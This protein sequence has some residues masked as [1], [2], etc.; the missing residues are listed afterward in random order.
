M[1]KKEKDAKPAGNGYDPE[2]VKQVVKSCEELDAEIATIMS[3]AM[4]ACKDKHSEK[5]DIIDDAKKSYGIP[6]K[7]VRAVL[8]IR[9]LERKAEKTRDDL[10]A[11]SQDRVDMI[12]H[13]LGDLAD[14]PLG[15]AAQ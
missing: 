1:A 14:T 8:K 2:Q 4:L 5:K 11:E 6:K 3:E 12:R 13:A 7:E 10:T 15:Q 9:S